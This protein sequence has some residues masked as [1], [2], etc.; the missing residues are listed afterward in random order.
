MP[1]KRRWTLPDGPYLSV[2]EPGGST[3]V[4]VLPNRLAPPVDGSGSHYLIPGW[5]GFR[6]PAGKEAIFN[7][8][9]NPEMG[10]IHPEKLPAE[11]TTALVTA[12][13]ASYLNLLDD[14]QRMCREHG[15]LRE[16]F[17]ELASRRPCPAN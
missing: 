14:A 8:D 2:N 12:H 9:D 16:Q 6:W 10:Y 7:P 5:V 3:V 13:R 1:P 11:E 15:E 4:C 17:R